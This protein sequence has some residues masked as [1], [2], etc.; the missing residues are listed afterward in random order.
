M[1]NDTIWIETWRNYK[2]MQRTD[3][4]LNSTIQ[5]WTQRTLC[6]LFSPTNHSLLS[7]NGSLRSQGCVFDGRER[8]APLK[9]AF[10]RF[11]V[12]RPNILPF[13]RPGSESSPKTNGNDL[14][15]FLS[16]SSRKKWEK[17]LFWPNQTRRDNLDR[18][19]RPSGDMIE[20]WLANQ[21]WIGSV[22]DLYRLTSSF[23]HTVIPEWSTR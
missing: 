11:W 2:Y 6:S 23:D 13:S 5:Y 19:R 9:T 4:Q 7:L 17:R 1:L 12:S 8:V 15:T 20:W 22:R 10:R 16:E 21:I 3:P 14:S 18:T